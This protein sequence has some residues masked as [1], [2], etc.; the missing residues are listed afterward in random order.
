MSFLSDCICG[1]TPP[2]HAGMAAWLDYIE[3]AMAC[4]LTLESDRLNFERLVT[5]IR[6]EKSD[7]NEEG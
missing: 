1:E 2:M 7:S 6:P 5:L 3:R 4:P